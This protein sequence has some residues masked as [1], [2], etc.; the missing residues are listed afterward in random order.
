MIG[1]FEKM[2]VTD[3][4]LADRCR[5]CGA[6]DVTEVIDLGMSPLSNAFLS[7]DRL[8]EREPLYPLRAFLCRSCMLVQLP[9]VTTSAEIFTEYVYFSSY[10]T[11]WLEHARSYAHQQIA[12]LGLGPGHKVVE[13]ASN[14]GYLLQFFHQA[15]IPVL[16]VEPAR[17]VA[18]SARAKG[19]PTVSEFFGAA[20]A[21]RLVADGFRADLMIANNVLAHVPD[22]HDFIAGF[23]IA[24]APD[25]TA[26][27]EFPHLLRLVEETQFDTIYHEHFSYLTLHSVSALLQEHGLTVVDVEQLSTHGGS[28][29]VWVRHAGSAGELSVR[30][31]DLMQAERAGGLREEE[32]YEAFRRR[33]FEIKSQLVHFLHDAAQRKQRVVGYGAAAKGNTLLNFCGIGSDLLPCV[34]DRNPHKQGLFLPGTHIPVVAPEVIAE[35]RPD[36][37][38]VLPWNIIDE[39]KEQFSYL[40][41]W[42]GRFVTAVPELRIA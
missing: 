19:I 31:R 12:R 5:Q 3:T 38:L 13:I 42:G 22:L 41:E 32:T 10:S 30:V 16:G 28:L 39:V 4:A 14:D 8:L 25:G 27:F 18:E 7:R 9:A 17:N 1:E 11:S 20:L 36:Y 33:V 15:G 37:L 2:R 29:R 40:G 24:L 34:A 35:L 23:A 26:S 21:R 6:S